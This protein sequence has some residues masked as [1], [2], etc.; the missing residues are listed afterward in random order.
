MAP[1]KQVL[2]PDVEPRDHQVSNQ[3]GCGG[4]DALSSCFDQSRCPL[5]SGFAVFFIEPKD[6]H[7]RQIIDKLRDRVKSVTNPNVACVWIQVQSS[8][9]HIDR[10]YWHGDGRNN[11][12]LLTEVDTLSWGVHFAVQKTRISSNSVES[13]YIGPY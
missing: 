3:A 13:S 1:P 8:L 6:A 5:T 7:F 11:V 2:A 10:T 12:I 4:L 9:A